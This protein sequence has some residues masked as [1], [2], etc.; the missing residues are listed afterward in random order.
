MPGNP[1]YLVNIDNWETQG[2]GQNNNLK[3]HNELKQI[4]V[5]HPEGAL[6]FWPVVPQ[7]NLQIVWQ[8]KTAANFN[9]I[10]EIVQLKMEGK[11]NS[12][13]HNIQYG[14]NVVTIYPPPHNLYRVNLRMNCC[15]II[16]EKVGERPFLGIII[17]TI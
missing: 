1:V 17:E 10:I 11:V 12:H 3:S 16:Q 2:S 13:K 15:S 6:Y 5:S 7:N 4:F 14:L 9:S 8:V